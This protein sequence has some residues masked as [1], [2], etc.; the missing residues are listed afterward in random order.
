MKEPSPGYKTT[1]WWGKNVLQLLSLAL[2]FY[3]AQNPGHLTADQQNAILIVAG[4]IVPPLMEMLYGF[5]RTW[6]K[7]AHALGQARATVARKPE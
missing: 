1:E 7:R 5:N 2:A 4:M 6:L 3:V